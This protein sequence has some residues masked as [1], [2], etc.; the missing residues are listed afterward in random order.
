M[1]FNTPYVATGST[2]ILREYAIRQTLAVAVS[3][4]VLMKR[5]QIPFEHFRRPHLYNLL[6]PSGTN[7]FI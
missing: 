3:L 6:M 7:I 5:S 1:I 2:W 4:C